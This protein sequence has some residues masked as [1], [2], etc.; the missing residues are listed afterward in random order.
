MLVT[1]DVVET[2][3]IV[4]YAYVMAAGEVIGEG[5]PEELMASS[6][7]RVTQFLKGRSDG[8][9]PFHYPAA[10]IAEELGL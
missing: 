9:V 4:D 2:F 5:T 7:P 3:R 10:P 6:D 8:P 1:H